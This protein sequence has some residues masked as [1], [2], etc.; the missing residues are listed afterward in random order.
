MIKRHTIKSGTGRGLSGGW[1]F[2]VIVFGI[3]SGSLLGWTIGM[4]ARADALDTDIGTAVAVI[5]APQTSADIP[6]WR[7]YAANAPAGGPVEIAIVIDDLGMNRANDPRA[8]ALSGPV[9]VAL[10]PYGHRLNAL[11]R[12]ARARGNEV[13]LHVPMEPESRTANPG[14]QALLVG[15]SPAEL[16]RRLAW[17]LA[18]VSGYV[19]ISNHMGSLF[20]S[21]EQDMALVLHEVARRGL[22]Y[23]DSRT[24]RRTLGARLAR[25]YGVPNAERNVFIDNIR[26]APE[27][28]RQL[29]RL[30]RRARKIGFAVGIG[31]PHTVTLAVL[32]DWLAG[33]RA[34]GIT[35]V[36]ISRIALHNW[37]ASHPVITATTAI[38]GY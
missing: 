34:R 36:P 18:R 12:Q 8:V 16:S 7:R 2:V 32:E 38:A 17:N 26:S 27:I 25:R 15:L 24:T 28:R 19:G 21:R 35:P 20:T 5:P 22:L 3:V 10:L 9:T 1:S 23:L 4:V 31:H 33:A 14:P 29:A 37:R 30:E 13:L 11:S 6:A